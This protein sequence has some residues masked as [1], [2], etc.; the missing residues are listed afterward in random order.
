MAKMKYPFTIATVGRQD[1]VLS[2]HLKLYPYTSNDAG[3]GKE[4]LIN[5]FQSY[6]GLI[7]NFSNNGRNKNKPKGGGDGRIELNKL[8]TV[9]L[10]TQACIPLLSDSSKTENPLLNPISYVPNTFGAMAKKSAMQIAT[11]LDSLQALQLAQELKCSTNQYAQRNAANGQY[12]QDAAYLIQAK[13]LGIYKQLSSEDGQQA[14]LNQYAQADPSGWYQTLVQLAKA[15]PE[16]LDETANT[17]DIILYEAKMKTPDTSKIADD[18]TTKV[19]SLS[20]TCN[21]HASQ[22]FCVELVTGR[23][24]PISGQLIGIQKGSYKEDHYFQQDMTC[25]EWVYIISQAIRIR[26]AYAAALVPDLIKIAQQADEANRAE[27]QATRTQPVQPV[28]QQP[29]FQQP[30]QQITFQQSQFIPYA[31]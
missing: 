27:S 8:D 13:K 24:I 12:I 31:Q 15:H 28:I 4:P 9:Y 23:G 7:L 18:G 26:D 14:I 25:E 5:M 6:S 2:A 21:P 16:Y 19:Y 3:K 30:Q 10:K 22:P 20:V 29:V 1:S 11:E 17:G